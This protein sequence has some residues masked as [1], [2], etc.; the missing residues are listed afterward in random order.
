VPDPWDGRP[1]VRIVLDALAPVAPAAL[2]AGRALQGIAVPAIDDRY[3]DAG[4]L[5]GI[6]SA[7]GEVDTDLAVVAACDMP[8]ISTALVEMMVELARADPS[9][10]VVMC[11]GERGL[12]PLLSVWRPARA[13]LPLRAAVATGT[14]ALREAVEGMPGL[15]VLPPEEWRTADPDGASFRN[16][17]TPA[18]LP[19]AARTRHGVEQNAAP[20]ATETIPRL[21]VMVPYTDTAP[22]EET[23]GFVQAADRLGYESVWVPEAYGYDGITM[24]TLLACRTERIQLATGIVNVFSRT[25]AL[26]GQTI[27]ALDD[28]SGGRAILGLGTSGP[29][30]I[31]GWHGV[32]FE[33][34]VQRTR[35]VVEIVRMVLRR[36]RVVYE[37][38][39]F[40]LPRGLKLITHPRRPAV[41][42]ALATLTDAGVA[43]TAEVADRWMP[44]LYDP[45]LAPQVFAEA[46]ERGRARRDPAL[47]PLEVC[48]SVPV[49]LG[50]PAEG[51]AVLKPYLALY[52]GGMGSRQRNF[53]NALVS[54]YGYAEEARRIQDL[55]LAGDKQQ[56]V[57]EV[58]DEL[59]DRLCVVGDE[60]ACRDGVASLLRRGVDVPLLSFANLY[61]EGRLRALEA[62]A[63]ARLTELS[64]SL[65]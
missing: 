17:N 24:L 25:P 12:E 1:L 3:F 29:Q 14:L 38:Q 8:S 44:T 34:G 30:V 11:R 16:W 65:S 37:G 13:L 18:D 15:L 28:I 61:A 23:V 9:L 2:L 31:E 36:E 41:P 33:K 26:I 52:L 19:E 21:G 35:E 64:G 40:Q 59:V 5:G 20:M 58:P 63:P 39:V 4:P 60:R 53:Y 7:L 51:R 32:K 49:Y 46:L 22:R 42:I 62:V 56:A 54:R 6:T 43:L 50:D 47:A 10:A 57:A 45:E 48:P 27:A 55:Y